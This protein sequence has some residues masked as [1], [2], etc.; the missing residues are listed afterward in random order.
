MICFWHF[1]DQK[2]KTGLILNYFTLIYGKNQYNIVKLNKIKLKKEKKTKTI[3]KINDF[4]YG[5]FSIKEG[6]Q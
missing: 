1:S 4:I 3:K 2:R 6:S 5:Y